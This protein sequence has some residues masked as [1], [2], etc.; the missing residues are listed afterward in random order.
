MAEG[1]FKSSSDYIERFLTG[2]SDNLQILAYDF[3]ITPT[4]TIITMLFAIVLIKKIRQYKY[5]K[6]ILLGEMK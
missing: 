1:L 4:A 2:I 5:A 6:L 3:I